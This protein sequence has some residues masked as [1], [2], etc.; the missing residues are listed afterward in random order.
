VFHRLGLIAIPLALLALGTGCSTVKSWLPGGPER[1][2]SKLDA[3][4]VPHAIERAE[5]ALAAGDA[6]RAL[7]WMTSAAEAS[8]LPTEQREQVQ[9]LLERSA[10]ARVEELSTSGSDPDE[11]ADMLDLELPRQIVVT[12]AVRAARTMFEAGDRM[13]AYHLIK[14]TDTK[15]PLHHERIAAGD[16]LYEIGASLAAD[17]SSFLGLFKKSDDAQEVLEY[18]ILYYP[19]ATNCD[20]AYATLAAIYE[21]DKEW[22]LAIDR[23]EKL[24]LNHSSSPLRVT[25]QAAVPRLR[26]AALRSPEYDRSEL[27][28]AKHELEEWLRAYSGNELEPTVRLYLADCMRRLSDNDLI[29]ARFYRTVD[30]PFGARRHA[31]RALE[32]ARVA[33]DAGRERAAEEFVAELPPAAPLPTVNA[34]ISP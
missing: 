17:K 6:E 31:E 29:V 16:L 13:D 11:L 28:R 2:P 32:E 1:I 34:A 19:W 15:F 18:L 22:E 24:V 33:Q 5:A 30:N 14:K 10:E 21:D 4:Q 9:R 27:L 12:A 23:H 25:S 7:A 20:H 3:E 8:G 26:L